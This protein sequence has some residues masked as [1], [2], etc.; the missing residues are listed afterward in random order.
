MRHKIITM[1]GLES[2]R[3][4]IGSTT[5]V[6]TNGCYDVL[7]AG[8]VRYLQQAAELAELLLVG[9]NDDAGVRALKGDDRPINDQNDRLE[10]IAGLEAVDAVCVFPGTRATEFLKLSRPTVWVKGGDY[11]MNSLNTAEKTAVESTG[12]RIMLLPLTPGRSTSEIIKRMR[13]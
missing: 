7:H 5:L 9:I 13:K 2:W 6:V 10:I 3:R 1:E 11:S 4:A 8:H 12:G